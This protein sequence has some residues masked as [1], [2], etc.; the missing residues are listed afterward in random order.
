MGLHYFSSCISQ[1]KCN[2]KFLLHIAQ[3]KSIKGLETLA[4]TTNGITLTRQLPKLQRAGLDLL[5]ISLDT[6]KPERFEKFTL[7]RGWMK[8]MA[9]ID[10]AIQLGYNPVK[11]FSLSNNRIYKTINNFKPIKYIAFL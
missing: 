1:A 9:S 7:R 4:M 2:L 6:L 10:L 11:V 5:N 8:V 3:L